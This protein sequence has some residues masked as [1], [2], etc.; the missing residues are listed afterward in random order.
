[1]ARINRHAFRMPPAETVI[2]VPSVIPNI[3]EL[4]E[5]DISNM[6]PEEILGLLRKSMASRQ[7]AEKTVNRL[8]AYR[9]SNASMKSDQ[10]RASL[11]ISSEDAALRKL[12]TA[13]R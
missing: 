5:T 1:M 11:L 9:F 2:D 3:K 4:S 12:I 6:S 13:R 8:K 7:N 10:R